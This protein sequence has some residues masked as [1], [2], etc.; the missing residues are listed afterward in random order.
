MLFVAPKGQVEPAIPLTAE[1]ERLLRRAFGRYAD[2][3]ARPAASSVVRRWQLD[4]SGHWILCDCVGPLIDGANPPA[5]V[6]V[7]ETHLR[8]HVHGAWPAHA[9][10]CDFFRDPEEQRDVT[11]S[12]R[13]S[14]HERPVIRGFGGDDR[15]IRAVTSGF[16]HAEERP[17]LARLLMRLMDDAGLTRIQ[18]SR[19]PIGVPEQ[20]RQLRA[21]ARKTILAGKVR[22]ASWL[23]TF[24]PHYEEFCRRIE[25]ASAETFPGTRPHGLLI[26]IAHA[27]SEGTVTLAGERSIEVTGRIAVFGEREGHGRFQTGDERRPPYLVAGL[28]ARPAPD[29]PAALLRVYAHPVLSAGQLL[30]VDS[31]Y[32][33]RTARRLMSVQTWLLK[34]RN[35]LM[36]I[37]KPQ[38]DIGPSPACAGTTSPPGAEEADTPPGP[39][40]IPDFVVKARKANG[41]TA[42]VIVETMGYDDHRYVERKERLHPLMRAALGDAPLVMHRCHRG[43][44][45]PVEVDRE[46]GRQVLRAIFDQL[47]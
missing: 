34:V 14:D 8:R 41:A 33:R 7:A 38:F 43:S 23:E 6:P 10:D 4:G 12:Y 3:A 18:P 22:L 28:V 46:M 9:A 5:L 11:R 47:D 29:A 32:E 39:P 13:R 17:P 31:D 19:L 25:A 2:P 36:T 1:E 15:P 44:G 45:D 27:V 16:S 40:L 26:G 35:I 20:Y 21:A 42:T 37:S 24:T 30:L